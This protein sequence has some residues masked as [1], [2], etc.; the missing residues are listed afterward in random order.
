[1]KYWREY[2][3]T[4]QF[5]LLTNK[6]ILSHATRN[7]MINSEIGYKNMSYVRQFR[8]HNIFPF[9]SQKFLPI[10]SE[11]NRQNKQSKPIIVL[12]LP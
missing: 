9:F 5:L 10:F 7:S 2:F 1:M 8:F 6:G 11:R 12:N 3:V 4:K